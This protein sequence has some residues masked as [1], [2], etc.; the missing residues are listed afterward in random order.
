MNLDY[1]LDGPEGAPVIVL[2]NSLG[3]TRA[4]WQPQM[5]ALT[6]RFRVLR[7]DT[8]GHGKTQKSGK[9]TL[10][11][12]GEDVIALL[13]HLNIAKAWFCGISMG[14]LTGLWLGRFA[15][16]RFYGIAV[17]NTAARIG[18]QASWLSRS[19]AVRQEGMDVVAAGAADRWF[20]HAFR[21]KA[22]EVVEALCHQLIHSNAEGYAECCEALAAA[23]LRSEV[24]QIRVPTLIIAG[25]SDPVTTVADAHFLH[26]QIPASQVV[27]VSASHLSSIESPGAFS[28]ALL[29]FLQEGDRGR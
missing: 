26:Q 5:A 27:V 1:Q 15:A 8:H 13:D 18:D 22:P 16:D 4:M 17:A 28:A 3:T 11:Q 25:E 24:G 23:D 29:A 2:S 20:T 9:V 12:L 14:G 6:Q 19:R 10:A 7:Y 21:Q